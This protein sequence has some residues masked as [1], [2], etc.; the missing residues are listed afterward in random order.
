[1]L[2]RATVIGVFFFLAAI[3]QLP[4]SLVP[5]GVTLAMSSP[6]SRVQDNLVPSSSPIQVLNRWTN[7]SLNTSNTI[8]VHCDATMFGQGLNKRDCLEAIASAPP[9]TSPPHKLLSFGNR[10]AGHF[11]IVLPRRYLSKNGLCAV[12]PKLV[13]G[14]IEA[15]LTPIDADWGATTVV[16]SCVDGQVS[17]G[18]IAGRIGEL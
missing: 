3:A 14:A 5:A 17:T 4:Q 18:G 9:V 10:Y 6:L 2:L 12:Q 15:H 7:T 8:L 1:M 13:R 11:D 16:D